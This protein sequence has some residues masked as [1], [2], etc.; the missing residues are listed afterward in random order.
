MFELFKR[1]ESAASDIEKLD[2]MKPKIEAFEALIAEAENI[3][4]AEDL[5]LKMTK[6]QEGF[7]L[8]CEELKTT[9]HGEQ[10]FREKDKIER[11]SLEVSEAMIPYLHTPLEGF[12]KIEKRLELLHRR[13]ENSLHDD[14]Y[15]D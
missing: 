10:Y 5:Q 8:L 2:A 7:Q 3:E 6:V 4:D 15:S 14:K 9:A 11:D 12:D 13:L 1:K